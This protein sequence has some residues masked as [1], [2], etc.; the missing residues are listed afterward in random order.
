MTTQ[1]TI[2]GTSLIPS[3]LVLEIKNPYL[4]TYKTYR[5][6]AGQ[7][8]QLDDNYPGQR[9]EPAI[10]QALSR[11]YITIYP[12][13]DE[14]EAEPQ[15]QVS[16]LLVNKGSILV[17]PSPKVVG[18]D[19]KE[20]KVF[21]AYNSAYQ[22]EVYKYIRK[23]AGRHKKRSGLGISTES[24]SSSYGSS[25][26]TEILGEGGDFP[27]FST[28]SDVSSISTSSD[29]SDISS[30]SSHPNDENALNF[31]F[32]Y[33]E[34]TVEVEGFINRSDPRDSLVIPNEILR[35]GRYW[36]VVSIGAGAFTGSHHLNQVI[37][38]S[39]LIQIKNYAFYDCE[40]LFFVNFTS[41][42]FLESIGKRAF[43]GNP[44][45]SRNWGIV[46]FPPSLKTI[47]EEAFT[48]R[49]INTIYF[50]GN[51]REIGHAAFLQHD[52]WRL[53]SVNFGHSFSAPI[54]GSGAFSGRFMPNVFYCSGATGFTETWAGCKTYPRDCGWMNF[55]SSSSS[56]EI[57]E[58]YPIHNG[59]RYKPYA[60]L[61]KKASEWQIP[62]T[63]AS[64]RRYFKFGLI[65]VA[66]GA[67]TMLDSQT[68][69]MPS[70]NEDHK[71][72]KLLLL[73]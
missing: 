38:P 33:D 72:S 9:D 63:W 22:V 15:G 60:I 56:M 30:I 49:Q 4:R 58:I 40:N 28:S 70:K 59:K 43:Y 52:P 17:Q 26:S 18:I 73:G 31:N 1:I 37:L 36:P 29:N 64:K 19:N 8:I 42:R 7:T 24:Q 39:G 53:S 69:F 61:P 10:Q 68:V 46:T 51:I 16:P 12:P 45:A 27:E 66:T 32:N 34:G 67:R 71:G 47:G 57:E 35:Y 2:T 54:V 11:G 20:G 25:N 55:E 3:V 5:I 41:L 50:T 23:R 44:F 13:E 14:L 48:Y 62:L 21:L 6:R 65:N